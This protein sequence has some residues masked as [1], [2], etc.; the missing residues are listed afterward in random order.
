MKA[1]EL[2]IGDWVKL[3]N[4]KGEWIDNS[5]IDAN[6]FSIA[7]RDGEDGVIHFE[8]IELTPEIL[9]KNGFIKYDDSLVPN[10]IDFTHTRSFFSIH[11]CRIWNGVVIKSVHEL[12]HAL[13]LS[14]ENDIAT[15]FQV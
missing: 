12:Q 1:E 13:R 3:C 8:P 15:N 10:Y 5:K 4:S 14:R 7:L 9:E 6:L 2:M 11:N